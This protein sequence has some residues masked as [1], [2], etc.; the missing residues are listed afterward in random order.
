MIAIALIHL[1]FGGDSPLSYL[2]IKVLLLFLPQL[3]SQAQLMIQL[4][5]TTMW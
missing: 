5:M 2:K 4:N 3:P 1:G